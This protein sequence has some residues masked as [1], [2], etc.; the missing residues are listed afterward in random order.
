MHSVSSAE[1]HL[2][3][4]I[5]TMEITVVQAYFM[6]FQLIPAFKRQPPWLQY[7]LI[8]IWYWKPPFRA[9]LLM[10]SAAL[11]HFFSLPWS[12]EKNFTY[13]FQWY[14][15]SFVSVHPVYHV[16]HQRC[17]RFVSAKPSIV[18]A[19]ARLMSDGIPISSSRALMLR[20][21]KGNE[22]DTTKTS[23]LLE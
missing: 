7:S 13:I 5:I 3:G 18:Q 17:N 4:T 14:C 16:F 8:T 22:D 19:E 10:T 23:L 6:V 12:R 21:V 2:C 15:N 9:M 1:V 11:L 20:E